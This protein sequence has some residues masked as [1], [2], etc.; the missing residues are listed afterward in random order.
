VLSVQRVGKNLRC[1]IGDDSGISNAFL[2]DYEPIVEGDYVVLFN[3]RSEV[4]KEHIEIQLDRRGRVEKSRR[5]VSKVNE[6]FNLSQKAWV[7]I[8]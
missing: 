3:A 6:D 1:V 7:P 2:P 4:V 8:E 5:E